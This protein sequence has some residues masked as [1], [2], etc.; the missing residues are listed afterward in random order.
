MMC[1]GKK[2]HDRFRD[3]VLDKFFCFCCV[4]PFLSLVVKRERDYGVKSTMPGR[5]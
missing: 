4:F 1:L 2:S 3:A 5:S